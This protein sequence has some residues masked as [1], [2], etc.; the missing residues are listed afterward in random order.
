[1]SCINLFRVCE[2]SVCVLYSI[3]SA[4]LVSDAA[5]TRDKNGDQLFRRRML[6]LSF[7][8]ISVFY[9]SHLVVFSLFPD[10]SLTMN[11]IEHFLMLTLSVIPTLSYLLHMVEGGQTL[12]KKKSLKRLG[13]LF[14]SFVLCYV[15]V[16]IVNQQ[17]FLTKPAR[18]M[19]VAIWVA[20][21]S[22]QSLFL[23]QI[24]RSVKRVSQADKYIRPLSYTLA[25]IGAAGLPLLFLSSGIIYVSV[26]QF[27]VW[28]CHGLLFLF[29]LERDPVSVAPA[30]PQ[31]PFSSLQIMAEDPHNFNYIEDETLF[32]ALYER[33]LNYFEKEK[34]YL[35]SGINV[36]DVA[37]KLSSNKS[38]VSH[39]LN[40]RLK[41]NFNQFVNGYRIQEAQRLV[42]KEGPIALVDLCKRVGFTS[43]ATFTVAFKLNTGMTPGEW[44]KKQKHTP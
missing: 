7:G 8:V 22:L 38:Y 12:F 23:Y 42:K 44:C 27:I 24:E 29:V 15:V 37:V 20:Q 6:A 4:I 34:P 19:G 35:K 40:D 2:I 1:M 43:M 30:F 39:L 25:A 21:V 36:L 17:W 9:F 28:I 16:R 18:L 13:A 41:M 11:Y 33:L 32:G 26:L 14:A 31:P 3:A 10:F 5:K